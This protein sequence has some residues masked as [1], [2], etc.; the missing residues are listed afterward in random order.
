MHDASECNMYNSASNKMMPLRSH[1]SNDKSHDC[2]DIINT[3]TDALTQ[4]VSMKEY[5]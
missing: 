1:R 5:K 3:N 2:S 4:S